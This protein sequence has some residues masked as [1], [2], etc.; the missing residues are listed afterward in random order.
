MNYP[1][2]EVYDSGLRLCDAFVEAEK[3][4]KWSWI[5]EAFYHEDAT[6]FCPYAGCMPVFAKNREEIAATHYGRDMDVGTGWKG[7]SFPINN[8][9]VEGNQIITRWVN[10][11]PG[12]RPDGS[13]YETE[14]VSF[15]TYGGGGKFSSQTDLFDL[16]HQMK[17]CDELKEAGLLDPALEAEW[18]KP[19]KRRL[20][21]SLNQGIAPASEP[22][23]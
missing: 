13:Y 18:V 21:D 11:G 7:W 14:G 17:L 6:Y 20:I 8:I 19:M 2:E 15:I 4:G 1:H 23:S 10:R 3:R 9:A 5:A 16:A 22:L 12:K